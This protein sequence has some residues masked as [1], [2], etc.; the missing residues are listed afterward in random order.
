MNR[1]STRYQSLL[2]LLMVVAIVI[3]LNVLSSY[4]YQRFDLTKEKRYT[5]SEASQQ[6]AQKLDDKLYVK[7][8]LDGE[9]NPGFK[10]LRLAVK[11]MMEEFR[12]ASGGNLEYEFEDPFE[13]KDE[14]QKQEIW[15]ELQKEG[16]R[17]REIFDN[18]T[19]KKSSKILIPGALFYYKTVQKLPVNFLEDKLF[20]QDAQGAINTSIE[21]LEYKIANAIRKFTSKGSRHIAFLQGHDELTPSE[22]AD[23]RYTLSENYSVEDLQ[24]NF[25]DSLFLMQFVDSLKGIT[26]PEEAGPKLVSAVRNKLRSYDA[27]VIAKPRIKF[28]EEE[29]YQIDQ[30]VM[31]GGK[32]IWMVDELIAELDSLAKYPTFFTANYDL[33]LNDMLFQYGV[34]INPDL[35]MDLQC[36]SIP[37]ISPMG[38]RTQMLMLDWPY[39]PVVTPRNDH[40]IVK[41]LEP[42]W[43]RF[44]SSIDTLN[45]KGLRKIPLLQSS[46]Y[47]K[48]SSNPAQVSLSDAGKNFDP[49]YFNKPDRILAV[50]LEG[51]FESVFKNRQVGD[52][53]PLFSFR[54]RIDTNAMIVISDGDVISNLRK[55]SG[56]IFPLG[57]DYYTG[58]MFANKK[59]FVNCVDYLLDPSGLLEVRNKE[60]KIRLLDKKKVELEKERWT[61]INMIVPV[62]FVLLFGFG[63][64]LLRRYK[65]QK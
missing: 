20:G 21:Q 23:I 29:K 49:R 53:D 59:F 16:L 8:Y 35:V 65:Y 45:K 6:L 26:N 2:E 11:D 33:N 18:E 58:R 37:N 43:F 1:K 4:L 15:T 48:L 17:P 19:D 62:V 12:R 38:S 41:N 47:T 60:L 7:V 28:R 57:Y 22:T 56:E 3:I 13:G 32:V 10:R 24:F 40:P 34:R 27:I 9:L 61:Y 46:L 30:Y 14:V 25:S 54:E 50:L 36:N 42:V 44:A 39:F 55:R 64:M 31:N 52:Y 5:L 63:N 51:R